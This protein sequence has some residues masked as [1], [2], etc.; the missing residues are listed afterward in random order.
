[1][2]AVF[3]VFWMMVRMMLRVVLGSVLMMFV[4][5]HRVAM[6][7]VSVVRSG[8]MITSFVVSVR[9]AVMVSG[10]FV[11]KRCM[12]MMVVLGHI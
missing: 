5:V 3:G 12:M 9:L 6:S 11:M 7:L 10:C 4:S 1:V 2:L 8:M